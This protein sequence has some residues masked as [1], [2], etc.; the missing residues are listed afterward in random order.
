MKILHI[1]IILL[2]SSFSML[3]SQAML[4]PFFGHTLTQDFVNEQLHAHQGWIAVSSTN[5]S[6]D[7]VGPGQC[8]P[9][10]NLKMRQGSLAYSHLNDIQ[11]DLLTPTKIIEN[12]TMPIQ[13]QVTNN[14]NYTLYNVTML[15]W[16]ANEFFDLENLTEINVLGP[17]QSKIITGNITFA[18][19]N[20]ITC[21]HYNGGQSRPALGYQVSAKNQTG[22]TMGSHYF[23]SEITVKILSPLKQVNSGI[24]TSNVECN[25][26]LQLMIRNE[27]NE[28]TCV[29]PESV[30]KLVDRGWGGL[31]LFG[32]P[33]STPFIGNVTN[34]VSSGNNTLPASFMTCDTQYELKQGFV[35]VLYMPTNSLGKICLRYSNPNDT[36]ASI[37][38]P[39]AF[40]PNNNDQNATNIAIW[41]YSAMNTIS[42]GNTTVAYWIKTGNQTGF[43]G[44]A[45]PSC[46]ATPFAVGYDN[47]SKITTSDF[48]FVGTT[49]CAVILYPQID[50]MT[51]IGVKYIPY[52]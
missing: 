29:T 28:P 34:S 47:D 22:E 4:T 44:L 9:Y 25:Q 27:D 46:G 51:G 19:K 26:G 12:Q 5:S 42:K 37:Y 3:S 2:V 11:L 16:A 10:F 50:S 49:S 1:L 38:P 43:Y 41:T 13:L 14:E 35:P 18:T 52:P 48:P 17:H 40:D 33:T 15:D 24:I 8:S 31:P 30:N 23:N 45:L 20:G 6:Q 7:Y 32:L 21:F 39:R 36:P